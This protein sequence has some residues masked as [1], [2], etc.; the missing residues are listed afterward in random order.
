M[1]P[2][3]LILNGDNYGYGVATIRTP[4]EHTSEQYPHYCSLLLQYHT[5]STL[6][7]GVENVPI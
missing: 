5:Y 2:F 7:R 4:S 6:F 3:P 1:Q